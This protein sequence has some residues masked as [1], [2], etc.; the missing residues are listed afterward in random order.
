MIVDQLAGDW[1]TVTVGGDQDEIPQ[2]STGLT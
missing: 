2:E 1:V